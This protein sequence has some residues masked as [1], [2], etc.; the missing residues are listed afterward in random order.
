MQDIRLS[1]GREENSEGVKKNA[2]KT[3]R[4][5]ERD[6]AQAESVNGRTAAIGDPSSRGV[7]WAQ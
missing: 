6:Q 5:I 4:E 3:E 1:A 2:P 7:H